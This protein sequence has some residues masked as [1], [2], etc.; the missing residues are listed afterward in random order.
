[1]EFGRH[2]LDDLRG[3]S[4]W[5]DDREP[6][7]ERAEIGIKLAHRRDAGKLRE[8]LCCQYRQ[9][10]KPLIA[11]ERQTDRG[12]L[13]ME[14]GRTAERVLDSLERRIVSDQIDWKT[15]HLLRI[16]SDGLNR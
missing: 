3:R 7:I 9:R 12:A 14:L 6:R 15:Q 16:S 1:M 5:C 10:P 2:S 13:N 11:D 4:G 8:P